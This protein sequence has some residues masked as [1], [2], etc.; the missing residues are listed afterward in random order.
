M[1]KRQKKTATVAAGGL[2][3]LF[4]SM[5]RKGKG[6]VLL[7][8]VTVRQ[9]KIDLGPVSDDEVQRLT[10]ALTRSRQLMGAD[11]NTIASRQPL[12]AELT[13]IEQTLAMG[14]MLNQRSRGA[15]P[16][17]SAEEQRLALAKKLPGAALLEANRS[18][19]DLLGVDPSGM[20]E[21]SLPL[22]S[23]TEASAR[24]LISKWRPYSQNAVD[25]LF[26]LLDEAR[27]LSGGSA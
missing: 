8:P 18:I 23:T 4:I 15:I 7:G 12:P 20:N 25:S 24:S 16:Y 21:A 2:M 14:R 6:T 13:Y 11:P 26:V 19:Y 1:N 9:E 5:Q 3:L 27:E 22:T 17:P 10:L